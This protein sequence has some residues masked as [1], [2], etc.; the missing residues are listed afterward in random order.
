MRALAF[1]R[2]GMGGYSGWS[3][4]ALYAP[5]FVGSLSRLFCHR[6]EAARALFADVARLL[7]EWSF[8]SLSLHGLQEIIWGSSADHWLAC[9]RTRVKL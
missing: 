2:I 7:S 9:S 4:H 1:L 5:S 6:H 8:W 3:F